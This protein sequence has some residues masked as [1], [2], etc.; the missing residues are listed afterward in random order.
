M[1]SFWR[2]PTGSMYL[3]SFF[4]ALMGLCV[5]LMTG[6]DGPSSGLGWS[7]VGGHDMDPVVIA[8]YRSLVPAFFLLPFVWRDLMALETRRSIP[9]LILRGVAG[10]GAMVLYFIAIDRTSLSTAVLLNYTSPVWAALLAGLFLKESVPRSILVAFP[11]AFSGVYLLVGGVG[12]TP[13]QEQMV[14]YLAGLGSA[15]LAGVAYTSVRSLGAHVSPQMVV[16]WFSAVTCVIV[17]PWMHFGAQVPTGDEWGL[18]LAAGVFAGIAQ[19][20]MTIGYQLN[21]AARASTLNIAT[22]AFTTVL[23]I[24]LLGE[25]FTARDGVGMLLILL[26][27]VVAARRKDQRL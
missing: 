18:L 14:G 11:I 9:L 7:V 19:W 24:A 22:V 23:A 17:L 8:F 4:F 15:F 13:T 27:L 1:R 12:A 25:R 16:F 6:S 10:G 2:H 26:G 3:S 5:K 20:A 21:K